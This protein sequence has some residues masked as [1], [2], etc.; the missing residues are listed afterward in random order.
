[1]GL[2]KSWG[3]GN[4]F[5]TERK[6][7]G[8]TVSENLLLHLLHPGG[9]DDAFDPHIFHE[10]IRISDPLVSS[11]NFLDIFC[12]RRFSRTSADIS[13]GIYSSPV[14][15]IYPIR[16]LLIFSYV[17]FRH[18]FDGIPQLHLHLTG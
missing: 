4:G 18:T 5:G 9:C 16:S 12:G 7:S 11:F 13:F 3:G 17:H 14:E 6:S 2:K 10:Q 15:S 1:M 8:G